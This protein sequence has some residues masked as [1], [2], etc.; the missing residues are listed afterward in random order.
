MSGI[1]TLEQH[2]GI[3]FSPFRRMKG[4]STLPSPGALSS[5]LQV[6][7]D[8]AKSSSVTISP[9]TSS[10]FATAAVE[11][12]LRAVHSFMISTSTTHSSPIWASVAGYYSSHYCVRGL[13]HLLGFFQL[14]S[15]KCIIQVGCT[16][17]KHWCLI[18][19]KNAG[20][21]EHKFYWKKVKGS[22]RFAND[23][24]FIFNDDDRDDSDSSHRS[25]ANYTDHVDRFTNFQPPNKQ[26]LLNRIQ[27]LS[28][29]ELSSVPIP[30][31]QKFPDIAAVQLIAYHRIVRFRS[32]LDEILGS[33]N[34]LWNIHR[35]PPW[36]SDFLDFQVV[37]PTF[38]KVYG[39]KA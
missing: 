24:F 12:W 10:L 31:R 4:C 2:I 29:V 27:F 30:N 32:F 39:T 9:D 8:K 15:R 3:L 35:S 19:K 33:S 23:P 7:V 20:D 38:L 18:E 14:R 21:R 37:E 25:H 36:C 28:T 22:A 26:E 5:K 17:G 34:R 6:V 16:G 11:M 1:S 13:G